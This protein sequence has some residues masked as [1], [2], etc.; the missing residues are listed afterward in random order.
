MDFSYTEEQQ[1]L[2][3]LARKILGDLATPDRLNEI[4]KTDDHF[5]REIWGELA[6]ANLLGVAIPEEYGGSGFGYPE[7]CVLLTE[8]GRT[9]VP[10]PAFATLVLGAL[11]IAKFGS[12]DQKKQLLPGVASGDTVLTAAL[13]E[14]GADDPASPTT[15]AR[16]DGDAWLLDGTKITVPAAHLAERMLVPARTAEG[17]TLVLIVDPKAAGVSLERQTATNREPVFWVTFSGARAEGVLGTPDDGAEIVSWLN[18][19][20]VTGLCAIQLGVSERA[21]E[22]TAEYGRTR[23]QFERPIGSFQAFH[24]RAADA[25]IQLEGIRVATWRAVFV[26]GEE[27]PPGDDVDVAK[28]WAAEGGHFVGYAAM[29]LH[30]GIGV[31]IDYPMHRYYI[32]SKFLELTLGSSH[33]ALDHIGRRMAAA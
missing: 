33:R 28:F 30:G 31:D 12:D 21:L 5:D 4:E 11:P 32:W 2:G 13:A 8:V 18:D 27:R 22:M 25:Y 26:L 14:A 23:E 6:K 20:A 10:I 16:R 24:T 1:A 15:A 17:R 3:E 29:H 7:L 9:V 19:R